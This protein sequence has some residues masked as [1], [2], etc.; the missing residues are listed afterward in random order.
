MTLPWKYLTLIIFLLITSMFML[1]QRKW[2]KEHF[3]LLKTEKSFKA[4]VNEKR[5]SNHCPSLQSNKSFSNIKTI[6][7]FDYHCY[8]KISSSTS[9]VCCCRMKRTVIWSTSGS[10]FPFW[11]VLVTF[12]C[13]PPSSSLSPSLSRDGRLSASPSHTRQ[14]INSTTLM[15][16]LWMLWKL[17]LS[18]NSILFFHY[19]SYCAKCTVLSCTPNVIKLT[20]IF[21]ISLLFLDH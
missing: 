4:S 7:I 5:K 2:K 18:E 13:L 6:P 19:V 16:L 14:V 15:H 9:T 3:R 17:F 20:I 12:P 8:V 21:L 10:C 11:R 1:I